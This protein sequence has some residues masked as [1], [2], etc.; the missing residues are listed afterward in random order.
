MVY[1]GPSNCNRLDD[2]KLC[3]RF[4]PS[5]RALGANCMTEVRCKNSITRYQKGSQRERNI[6][7]T[8]VL[9]GLDPEEAILTGVTSLF[10]K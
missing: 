9:R 2:Q 8:K 1:F 6:R 5:M 3:N 4:P 7:S 10:Y